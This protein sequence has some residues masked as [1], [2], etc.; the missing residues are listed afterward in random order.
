MRW[1]NSLA[2]ERNHFP[3]LS[4]NLSFWKVWWLQKHTKFH[5]GQ[6][7]RTA[8]NTAI[9]LKEFSTLK[10]FHSKWYTGFISFPICNAFCLRDRSFLSLDT[11]LEC[12][13]RG[14]KFLAKNLRGLKITRKILRG[15][16]ITRKILRGL[17]IFPSEKNKGCE[18]IRGMK[19]SSARENKAP[20]W[21]AG[22]KFSWPQ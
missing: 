20:S 12:F 22:K 7:N 3:I 17:K 19:F 15:L 14:A 1:I 2:H 16:K 10:I 9:T 13:L 4:F 18:T 21:N 8:H 11:R 6:L 5:Y